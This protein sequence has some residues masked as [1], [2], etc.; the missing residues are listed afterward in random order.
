MLLSWIKNKR[1]DKKATQELG[2]HV[3]DLLMKIKSIVKEENCWCP[4]RFNFKNTYVQHPILNIYA[5]GSKYYT[6][7]VWV[8]DGNE[9]YTRTWEY[10]TEFDVTFDLLTMQVKEMAMLYAHHNKDSTKDTKQISDSKYVEYMYI[11]GTEYG[12]AAEKALQS[13]PKRDSVVKKIV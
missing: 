2:I 11:I 8:R 5:Q 6:R 10:D 7:E 4:T 13:T 3:Y 12:E 9:M 1:K